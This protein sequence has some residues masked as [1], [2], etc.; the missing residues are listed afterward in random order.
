MGIEIIY[1]SIFCNFVAV[2]VLAFIFIDLIKRRHEKNA[3]QILKDGI[4]S[5]F[6][7]RG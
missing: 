4:E 5:I 1:A 3:P 6:T 7:N 2:V